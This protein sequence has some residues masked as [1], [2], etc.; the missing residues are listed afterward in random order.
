MSDQALH[1]L[2]VF[3]LLTAGACWWL[4]FLHR[5][6]R[7]SRPEYSIGRPLL[8]G[9]LARMSVLAVV[10]L[11]GA[12]QSLRGADEQGFIV[13]ANNLAK[14][15]LSQDA[16][17][18]VSQHKLH[19]AL[20]GLQVKFL[21]ADPTTM[22][23]TEIAITMTGL[24]LLSA[25]VYDLA[26]QRA[27]RTAAWLMMLEPAGLFFSSILHKEPLIYLATGL[28]C[29]GAVRVWKAMDAPGIALMGLG[30]YIAISTRAYAGYFLLASCLFVCLHA[31]LLNLGGRRT[32]AIPLLLVTAAGLAF[33]VG[34]ALDATSSTTLSKLQTS[35]TANSNDQTA[36]LA[37][38]QV[39]YSTRGSI[40][41]SAPRR[42]IDVLVRPYPWQVANTA[43]QLGVVGTL[44]A[45]AT[46]GLLV[47]LL[48]QQ[49][50]HVMRRAGPLLY[51]AGFL[52]VAYA[53]SAGNAG[54]SFRYRTTVLAMGF[55]IVVVLYRQRTSEA[56]LPRVVRAAVGRR[57]AGVTP[58]PS[59]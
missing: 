24:V 36:N 37:L 27:A 53:L 13:F 59:W 31:S 43:Q 50:G 21:G 29:L 18:T 6:L 2:E 10:G 35:Q 9:F 48:W 32:R 49:R 12:G 22:R 56:T 28:V 1:N 47:L 38:E 54:T 40:A 25:A 17:F 11:T 16:W 23:V 14:I 42:V 20:M 58:D 3:L 44:A 5:L 55:A 8:V 15:P 51:P 45:L 57:T 46:L 33:A 7:R 52:L 30:C 19:I 41:T 39:D 34:P 4:P 26:G